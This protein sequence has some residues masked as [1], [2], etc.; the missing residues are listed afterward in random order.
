MSQQAL[1]PAADAAP[2][3]FDGC[4]TESRRQGDILRSTWASYDGAA[5]RQ[6]P[7]KRG[8]HLANPMAAELRQALDAARAKC[9]QAL[10]IC[11][12]ARGSP[13]TAD[14]FRT[15]FGKAQI[16]AGIIGITFHDL[17]GTAV[18]RLAAAGCTVPEIAQITGHGL[19]DCETILDRHSFSRDKGLGESAIAK[20]EQ[21]EPRTKTVNGPVNSSISS[22][23]KSD[24]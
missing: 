23:K 24:N 15:S 13:W 3:A 14:S 12:I 1:P 11:T 19:K 4:L 2:S 8:K 9:G 5:V 6:R 16:A 21:H 18:T 22:A 10:T 20:V 7:S 17:R